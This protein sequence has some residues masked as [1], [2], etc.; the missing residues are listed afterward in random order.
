MPVTINLGFHVEDYTTQV[1]NN[2]LLPLPID[3][4]GDYGETFADEQ[5]TYSLDLGY[6]M[7]IEK[8]IRIK[9]PDGWTAALPKDI[10]YTVESAELTR[11]YRQIENIITY[12]LVFTLKNRILSPAAYSAARSL[13]TALASE[14][15]TR[16]LLNTGAGNRMSRK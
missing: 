7:Q 3:E 9:I 6:P 8:E 11:Q 1:G 13:F 5:R 16:L 10:H 14:D 2:M 15:G 12:R 4:F